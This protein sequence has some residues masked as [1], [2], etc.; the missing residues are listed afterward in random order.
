MA[1]TFEPPRDVHVCGSTLAITEL[2]I[3][4]TQDRGPP[5]IFVRS[6]G[7]IRAF[8]KYGCPTHLAWDAELRNL[9]D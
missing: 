3:P 8:C 2:M 7:R 5:Y 6:A 4:Y 1:I 9:P